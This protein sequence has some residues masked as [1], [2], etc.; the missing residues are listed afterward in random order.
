MFL[1][2]IVWIQ[3]FTRAGW[4]G[5]RGGG[6]FG[7]NIEGGLVNALGILGAIIA[8]LAWLMIGL[9]FLFDLSVPDLVNRISDTIASFFTG[10]SQ[11]S[12]LLHLNGNI[13]VNT[14]H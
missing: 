4:I 3:L 11:A 2:V 6:W 9:T 1:N 7:Q 10:S 5:E 12:R 8:L 14:N 13:S